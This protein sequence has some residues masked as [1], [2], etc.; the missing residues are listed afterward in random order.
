VSEALE[1][2]LSRRDVLISAAG[3]AAGAAL[4]PRGGVAARSGA[5]VKTLVHDAIQEGGE[6]EHGVHAGTA[7]RSGLLEGTGLFEST[8]VASDFPFTHVGLHWRDSAQ[9]NPSKFEARTSADGTT[10]SA[11]Q[12]LAVEA[13][14]DETPGGETY[15]G[16]A[17]APRHRF[18]QYRVTLSGS[19]KISRVTSTFI[20]TA[21]GPQAASLS[22]LAPDKPAVIDMSRE[23]WG[24]DES[25]RFSGG[26]EIWPRMFVPVKKLLV[27][28]TASINGTDPI[29]DIR[30]IYTYHAV[31]LGWGDIGYNALVD[32]NGVTYEGRYGREF[33]STREVFGPDVVA[34]HASGHNYGTSSV[35]AMG[36]FE[37]IAP[38]TATVN[39][40]IDLLAY[41]ASQREI[42]PFVVSDFLQS[43]GSWTRGLG[44]VCGHRDVNATACPGAHLY[45]QL[46]AIQSAVASRLGYGSAPLLS[47]PD[48]STH[49]RGALSYSW[50]TQ[51]GFRYSYYLEGWSKATNSEAI[52]YLEGYDDDRFPVWSE[53]S[54]EVSSASFN[55]LADGHY[56]FH[57]KRID[58]SGA[59]SYQANKTVLKQGGGG[60]GG[61]G[62]G[63]P[64]RR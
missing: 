54:A 4:L 40:I 21:D 16:L 44:N 37:E 51:A 55:S 47:G 10:W 20:N 57:L 50:A 49:R 31:T 58:L 15:L 18:L 28:H 59:T 36:N 64:P 22:A 2:R 27:H 11:W 7:V 56:T 60:G 34:G 25:L 63:R 62:G 9:A 52:G 41:H 8:V 24:C 43:G 39:S 29:Q 48:G 38:T 42:D 14:P 12:A 33:A 23:D 17:A 46:S 19:E 13:T 3:L 53:P 5:I 32:V 1:R 61:G 30:A 35:S 6:F 45:S 26:N